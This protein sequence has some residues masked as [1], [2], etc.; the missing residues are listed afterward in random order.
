MQ[1]SPNGPLDL[2]FPDGAGG[3]GASVATQVAFS[4]AAELA[5][6]GGNATNVQD[7]IDQV[8]QFIEQTKTQTDGDIATLQSDVSA[9]TDTVTNGKAN[10]FPLGAAAP[11]SY[12]TDFLTGSNAAAVDPF[13]AVLI[14]SGTINVP[15]ISAAGHPGMIRLRSAAGAGSGVF[16]GSNTGQLLIAGG[17]Y[18]EA[19][20]YINTLTDIT[21]R[22]G[23]LDTA[24]SADP[25]DGA[26]LQIAPTG[27]A[28][29]R[30]VN[31]GGAIADTDTTAN[32]STGTWYKAIVN[33]APDAS[34]VIFEITT[35]N[36]TQVWTDNLSGGLPTGAGRETGVGIIAT[37][38]GSSAVDMLHLDFMLFALNGTQPQRG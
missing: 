19:V 8:I 24:T 9:L 1:N 22:M 25:S 27:V 18:F 31:N 21:I 36:G 20:F 7:A 23:F 12:W 26:W 10:V 37:T 33:V 30:V 6:I 3:G 34:S 11:I 4:P 16:V 15:N 17:E 32:L 2:S 35:M 13:I 28:T 14:S 5:D 29:G 38:A